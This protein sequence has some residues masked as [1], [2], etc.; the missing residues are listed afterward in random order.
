MVV[1]IVMVGSLPMMLRS[2]MV[3]VGSLP[4]VVRMVREKKT[5]WM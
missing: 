3:M 1:R 4:M 5:D 2:V